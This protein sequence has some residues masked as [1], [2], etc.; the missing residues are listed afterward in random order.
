MC[1]GNGGPGMPVGVQC[2]LGLQL[3]REA[4]LG[5]CGRRGVAQAPCLFPVPLASPGSGHRPAAC[6]PR[7]TNRTP[8][9]APCAATGAATHCRSHGL[10]PFCHTFW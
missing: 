2:H 9:S 4:A 1:T 8:W 7:L 6:K 5:G 10:K 3:G